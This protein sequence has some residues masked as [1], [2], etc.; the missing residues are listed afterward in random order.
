MS[1]KN[2]EQTPHFVLSY[3]HPIL[4]QLV[5]A[6]LEI[7]SLVLEMETTL[8]A[9]VQRRSELLD[10]KSKRSVEE[11]ER[12]GL[13]F[14]GWVIRLR[15]AASEIRP[16][17]NA[18]VEV[19]NNARRYNTVENLQRGYPTWMQ[20]N[21]NI[22]TAASFLQRSL[23]VYAKSD[24]EIGDATLEAWLAQ[25]VH[26]SAQEALAFAGDIPLLPEGDDKSG[27]EAALMLSEVITSFRN[28]PGSNRIC[29]SMANRESTAFGVAKLLRSKGWGAKV[30]D[31]KPDETQGLEV[32]RPRRK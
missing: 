29:F 15:A 27:K 31:S 19:L 30:Q 3:A 10:D 17:I 18:L 16:K 26:R 9:A 4:T 28:T 12:R 24:F 25:L 21:L 5:E 7:N 32:T 11:K 6:Y 2:T 8:R 1:A 14:Y 22:T 20:L 13:E 23:A